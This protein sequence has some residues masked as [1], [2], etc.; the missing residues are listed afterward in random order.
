MLSTSLRYK[1]TYIPQAAGVLLFYGD[2][3]MLC[4]RCMLYNGKPVPYAG[5]WSPFTGAVEARESPIMAAVRELKEES[6]LDV[7]AHSLRYI[8]E[9]S[10]S[11]RSLVLYA[12]ELSDYFTPVLDEEH[13]EYGYFKISDLSV[14]PWP[15][16]EEV[17][18][19]IDLYCSRLRY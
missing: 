8:Q 17:K 5:H 7:P 19:A 18:A 1:M 15:V 10:R 13:T 16:D 4:K 3:V 12:H 9:I 14:S 6:G 2:L 11:T